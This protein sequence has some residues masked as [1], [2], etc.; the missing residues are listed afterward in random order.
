MN[1][2]E[3]TESLDQTAAAADEVYASI[4][5]FLNPVK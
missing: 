1:P 4:K 3:L 5:P 2:K